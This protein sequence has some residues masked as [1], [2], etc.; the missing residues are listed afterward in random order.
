MIC[1]VCVQIVL[2]QLQGD[3]G[4]PV[5]GMLRVCCH[6]RPKCETKLMLDA[7]HKF[8]I[9]NRNAKNDYSCLQAIQDVD[10]I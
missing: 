4:C 3:A 5:D 10:G 7:I 6:D 1:D 2:K 8:T 9:P